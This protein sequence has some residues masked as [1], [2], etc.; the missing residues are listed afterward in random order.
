V[1]RYIDGFERVSLV[2]AKHREEELPLVFQMARAW[3]L[4]T[5]PSSRSTSSATPPTDVA[6]PA[7][8]PE[9]DVARTSQDHS[10]TP[11]FSKKP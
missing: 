11:C 3:W 10:A 5:S 9:R 7:V 4:T 8:M 2:A 1:D 6:M